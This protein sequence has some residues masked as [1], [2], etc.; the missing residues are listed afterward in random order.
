MNFSV[1]DSKQRT[2]AYDIKSSIYP[3]GLQGSC[4]SDHWRNQGVWWRW[5]S[6]LLYGSRNR[7]RVQ[8]GIRKDAAGI[9]TITES[10]IDDAPYYN[11]QGVRIE[12]PTHGVY[13]HNGKK[14]V[15]K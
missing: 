13:I 10:D 12:K 7:G 6:H 5:D 14:V 3:E 11:L 8:P 15:I 2:T 9:E 4:K 1:I